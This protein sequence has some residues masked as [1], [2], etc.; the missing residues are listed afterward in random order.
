MSIPLVAYGR[1]LRRYLIVQRGAAVTMALLLLTGTGLDLAVPQVMRLFVD[2]AL[3]GAARANLIRLALAYT[4]AF[5]LRRG[6]GMLASYWSQR[7]AWTATNALRID[8]IAHLVRLDLSYHKAHTP[9]ELIERID[10]DVDAMAAFFSH[11]VVSLLGSLLTLIGILV[12]VFATDWRLG[13]LFC[14]F[15]ALALGWLR[16]IYRFAPPHWEADRQRTAELYGFMGETLTATEDIRACGAT[17]YIERR[18]VRHLRR[19]R[20]AVLRA[21]L[22]GALWLA[23][24]AIASASMAAVRGLGAPLVLRRTLSLGTLFMVTRYVDLVIWGPIWT[25]QQRL[26]DLQHAQASIVRVQELLDTRSAL[27]DGEVALPRGP[28]PVA[29]DRVGFAYPDTLAENGSAAG[30]QEIDAR[31]E[32]VVAAGDSEPER[33]ASPREAALQEV[34]FRLEAGRVLGLL[35]R[36]GSGKTTIARL[37]YRFYDPQQ[38]QIRLGGV[39]LRQARLASLRARVGLVT[40]DVQLLEGTLRD[41]LCFYDAQVSDEDLCAVLD[42][43]GLEGWLARFPEGLDT[44][45]SGET[46]SAGEA[47]L[48]A[49]ARVYLKDPDL[50]VLDEASSRLDPAT[51]ALLGRALERLLQG[52]TAVII[53]HRLATVA[54][55]DDILI[56]GSGR[57]IEQ[58]PREQLAT[59]ARSHL[60]RLLRTGLVEVL[61]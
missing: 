55:A 5:V 28:T 42:T 29:F 3:S 34:S 38:G 11:F 44:P 19:W 60:S 50:V 54:R 8:L 12:V 52:R 58:G 59:D 43:L 47:Q 57:V 53:A 39:D 15:S 40:Q 22:W 25:L 41:N 30:L 4:L 16:W 6:L 36:T 14:L 24:A 7:V 17:A 20:P 26:E 9:G 46:L 31:E 21:H 27:A 35:G 10:G 49:L 13:A 18:F 56:L 1:L 33:A 51:E 61:T 37:L 45:I 32:K 23:G 48:V 2:G